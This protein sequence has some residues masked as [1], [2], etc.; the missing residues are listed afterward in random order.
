MK[1]QNEQ[2]EQIVL[3][4]SEYLERY[5]ESSKKIM[6]DYD[7]KKNDIHISKLISVSPIAPLF[8]MFLEDITGLDEMSQA[9]FEK[10]LSK[11]SSERSLKKIMIMLA[12]IIK[13]IQR[14]PSIKD[15]ENNSNNNNN[16]IF[17]E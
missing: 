13:T 1:E 11:H 15:F 7:F 2:N 5:I 8:K 9:E 16:D 3:E 4:S 14:M 6:E 10:Y 12:S 17:N